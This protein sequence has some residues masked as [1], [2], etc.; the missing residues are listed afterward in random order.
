MSTVSVS[1]LNKI[2]NKGK[3]NQ[4]DALVERGK[5]TKRTL[6]LL[7]MAHG[8]RIARRRLLAQADK[9]QR[10]LGQRVADP[11]DRTDRAAIDI[12]MEHLRIDTD[13]KHDRGIAAGD[14]FCCVTQ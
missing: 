9:M 14:V 12:A 11:G 3:S 1:N 8:H 5:H 13:Q 2:F 4:V 7:R 6:K 10:F